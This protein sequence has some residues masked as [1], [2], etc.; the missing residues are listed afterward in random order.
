[1]SAEYICYDDGRHL[2]KYARKP[3]R[4]E[5]TAT[6]KIMSHVN[7]VVDKMNMAG[8][9]DAW[10]KKT[11][12]PHLFPALKKVEDDKFYILV[13]TRFQFVFVLHILSYTCRLTLRCASRYF[14]GYLGTA[15]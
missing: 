13:E 6:S 7:I 15:K 12:D 1:M 9:V 4:S 5:M 2:Q 8:H 14:H 3:C 10:C 11:C